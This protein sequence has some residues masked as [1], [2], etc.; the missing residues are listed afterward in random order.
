MAEL[1]AGIDEG[2]RRL[3]PVIALIDLAID[4]TAAEGRA[5]AAIGWLDRLPAKLA[6]SPK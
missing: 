3:G 4:V 5:E 1:L 2:V 6:V